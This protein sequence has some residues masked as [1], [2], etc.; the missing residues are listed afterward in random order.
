M[1][2][3]RVDTL[4]YALSI[5]TLAG[6]FAFYLKPFDRLVHLSGNGDRRP[7][8]DMQPRPMPPEMPRHDADVPPPPRALPASSAFVQRMDVASVYI[9]LLVVTIGALFQIVKY[10]L[11]AQRR[12]QQ[13][14]NDRMQ[15]ELSFLKAQVHPHFLFNTLNNIYSLALTDDPAVAGS[16][17]KLSQLMRYYMDERKSGAVDTAV[18]IHAIQ[19]FIALQRLRI[20][21]L[22][23]ISERYEGQ[24]YD[25]QIQPF[26]LLPFVENAFKYGLSATEPC[27]LSFSIVLCPDSCLLEVHNSIPNRKS[28]QH[29]SGTGLRN[30]KR[31]LEYFYPGRF[32]LDIHEN[33]RSFAIKLLLYI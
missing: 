14:E 29:R 21:E 4:L 27:T 1:S 26:I 6:L 15:A 3:V 10:W 11:E 12:M 5:I 28:E 23:H 32:T 24:H 20:S 7:P 30:T 19:D 17:H 13:A 9:F 25:K 31:L 18:E 2:S 33:E 16:I 22:C 8:T